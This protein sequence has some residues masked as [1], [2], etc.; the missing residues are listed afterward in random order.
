MKS[1]ALTGSIGSGKTLICSVFE[2]LGIPVFIADKE[3]LKCY[4]NIRF[5]E[6]IAS[7]FG[8]EVLDNKKLNKKALAN[9]VFND[10][11]KLD[12]LN[13][14]IHPKVLEMYLRQQEQHHN[15]PYTIMESAIIFEIGWEK[16]FDGIICID[17]P[18]EVSIQRAMNRDKMSYEE[19]EQ[20]FRNQLTNEEKV[21]RSHFVIHHD[22][23]TMLL[24][25]ILEIHKMIT[26]E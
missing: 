21:R 17:S 2:Q 9:I 3:A 20:R 10:S 5:L 15:S 16:K 8:S 1:I 18:K 26:T 4:N 14:M 13:S 12:K 24:P 25:Q 11:N 22:N 7:E 6:E 23:K 19:V